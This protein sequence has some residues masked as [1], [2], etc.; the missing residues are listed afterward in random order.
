MERRNRKVTLINC[1]GDY[2]TT[3]GIDSAGPQEENVGYF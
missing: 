3:P 2:G 1:V